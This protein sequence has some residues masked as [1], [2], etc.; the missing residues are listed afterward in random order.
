LPLAIELAAAPWGLLAPAEILERLEDRF[1][2]LKRVGLWDVTPR[3]HTLQAAVDWSYHLV[4]P[5]EQ[6]LFL[7]LAVYSGSFDVPAASAMVGVDA[8]DVLD[9]WWTSHWWWRKS[10]RAAHAIGFSTRCG[11]TPGRD[12]GD[13]DALDLGRQRHLEYSLRSAESLFRVTEIVDGPTRVPD[14]NLNDL[15]RALEWCAATD[16]EAGLRLI[17]ATRPV[18]FRR[19]SAEGRQWAD[20]FLARC[21]D[22]TRARACALLAV[23]ELNGMGDTIRARGALAEVV[24]IARMLQ[25]N[26]VLIRSTSTLAT[27]ARLKEQP[28]E[29]LQYLTC[30]LGR[31]EDLN[32]P[33]TLGVVLVELSLTLLTQSDRHDEAFA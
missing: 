2:L 1:T 32:D 25:D 20:R 24:E 18:W 3:Q 5:A 29:A 17:V 4:E 8:L 23:R 22:A 28:L 9:V 33:G 14:A 19:D 26:E 31:A 27:I 10:A 16:A 12:S 15:R 11:V 30:V 13:A 7:R 6:E 21:P